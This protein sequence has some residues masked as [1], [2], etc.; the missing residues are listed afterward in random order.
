M[1][2]MNKKTSRGQ[3]ARDFFMQGYNCSQALVCA[4]SDITGLNHKT[5]A[6]LASSFGGGMGRMR[7][8]CGTV[9]GSLMVLGLALGYDDPADT[10]AKKAHY[11]LVQ[12]YARR[13]REENGSI[14]CRDLLSGVKTTPGMDPEERTEAYYKKRPCPELVEFA[15]ELLEEI[16]KE[17]GIAVY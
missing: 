13:F 15:A 1:N 9:S 8:V 10:G 5:A 2:N 12:E 17:N 16:L 6:R 11:H 4:F 3:A 7:E 14:I